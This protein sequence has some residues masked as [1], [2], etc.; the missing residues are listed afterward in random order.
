MFV[1]HPI[2]VPLLLSLCHC[3]NTWY[4]VEQQ[5]PFAILYHRTNHVCATTKTKVVVPCRG[6]PSNNL[7]PNTDLLI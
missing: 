4:V 6:R 5:W 2:S 1:K 7:M 3:Q